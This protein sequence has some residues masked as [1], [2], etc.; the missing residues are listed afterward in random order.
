MSSPTNNPQSPA[1]AVTSPKGSKSPT[2]GPASPVTVRESS[3]VPKSKSPTPAPTPTPGPVSPAATREPS[4]APK[5]P[6]PAPVTETTADATGLLPG[7]HWAGQNLPEEDTDNDWDSTLGTEIES[8]TASI[9]SSILQYRT[10]NGRTY[11]SESV[12]NTPYWGPNDE[13]QNELLDIFHHTMTIALDGDL[14]KAPIT[15]NP[16]NVLDIGTGTGLWAIDFADKFPQCSVIGTDLS[17]IQP[18]WVPANIRFDIDDYNKE[19]TYKADFFDLIH[20]RWIT[21]TVNNWHTLYKE[22]YRC[23]KPGGWIEHL[24]CSGAIWSD[25]GTVEE[26]MAIGQWGKIWQEAGRRLGTPFD[27]LEKNTQEEGMR[28]AGFVNISKTTYPK[29]D[30]PTEVHSHTRAS[31]PSETCVS[32]TTMMLINQNQTIQIPMSPWSKEKKWK[33]VGIYFNAVVNQ[34]LEGATQFLF[35]NIMGWTKEE[36]T[37]YIAVMKREVKNLNIHGYMPYRLVYAQKPLNA[38]D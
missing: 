16:K 4:A 26:D 10:I 9:S 22:A 21:G 13:K 3:V 8:S 12:A 11:H 36:I 31:S 7:A 35:G 25:D 14:Y 38:E 1:S 17:P 34:D 24:D 30:H 37:Q 15:E 2:P 32:K 5:S 19:W 23:C 6:T 33:E 20:M 28:G 29:Y 18:S 27:I